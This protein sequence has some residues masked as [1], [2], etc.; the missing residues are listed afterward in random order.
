MDNLRED[1]SASSGNKKEFKGTLAQ[2]LLSKK[3]WFTHFWIVSIISILGLMYMGAATYMGAPPVPDFKN[4]N[5]E[6]VITE[7]DIM[8]G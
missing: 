7:A 1:N 6:I 8:K 2:I 3:Y 5:G 4:T